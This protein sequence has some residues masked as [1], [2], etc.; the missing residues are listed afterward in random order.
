MRGDTDDAVRGSRGQNTEL[1]SKYN[2]F[3]LSCCQPTVNV[4]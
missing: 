1:Y 2:I 3:Q 4:I